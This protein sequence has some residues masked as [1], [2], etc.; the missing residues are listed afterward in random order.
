MVKVIKRVK[1]ETR[2]I[3]IRVSLVKAASKIKKI[4]ASPEERNIVQCRTT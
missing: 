1:T 2:K 4:K 3:K